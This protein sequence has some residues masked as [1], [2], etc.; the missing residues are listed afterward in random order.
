MNIDVLFRPLSTIDP[1]ILELLAE[2]TGEREQAGFEPIKR[3]VFFVDNL[4]AGRFEDNLPLFRWVVSCVRKSNLER[5]Y[6]TLIY[7][8]K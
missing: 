8:Q 4:Y 5:I 2:E 1:N 3:D 6:V 7:V